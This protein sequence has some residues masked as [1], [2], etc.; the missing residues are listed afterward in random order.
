MTRLVECVP[1]FSEGRDPEVLSALSA[2]V[3]GTE[4]AVLLDRSMDPD[5][6]RCVLTF[7]GEPD[8]VAEAAVRAIR[9]ARDRINL[10]RHTGVH[11][12]LGAA[13]VV[14][15]IPLR[16][17]MLAECAALASR[18]R[19]ARLVGVGHSR[20]SIRSSGAAS[21]AGAARECAAGR[22]RTPAR[23]GRQR[24]RRA[25]PTSEARHCTRLPV[26]PSWA[27]DGS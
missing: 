23:S 20:L 3:S 1:N 14:P 6:N 27:L 16:G 11:P 8:A 4:G 18:D 25:S 9:V 19:R 12:R 22:V 13:D 7:A 2:A 17:M 21:G 15:F 24:I 10:V 5:H 26:R